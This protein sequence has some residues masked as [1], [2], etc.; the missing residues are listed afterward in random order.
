MY[1]RTLPPR[2]P[3]VGTEITSGTGL[4]VHR[5]FQARR[6]TTRRLYSPGELLPGRCIWNPPS[7]TSETKSFPPVVQGQALFHPTEG[8]MSI[9]PHKLPVRAEVMTSITSGLNSC[10]RSSHF[11]ILH[12]FIRRVP[13]CQLVQNIKCLRGGRHETCTC[14]GSQCLLFA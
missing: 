13:G 9:D 10:S 3:Q 11:S 2:Y 14:G 5:P 1:V 12:G 8:Y 6:F 4:R 7:S